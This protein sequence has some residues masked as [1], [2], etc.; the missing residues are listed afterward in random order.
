MSRF[1]PQELRTLRNDIS[2][3]DLLSQRLHLPNKYRDSFLRFLCPVCNEFD[4]AVNPKTNLARCFRC[5]KNFNPIDL[6][7]TVRKCSFL[8]AVD[9]LKKQN[10]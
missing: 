3:A 5:S 1:S 9:F 2:I 10:S 8:D 7:M 6:V 4:T